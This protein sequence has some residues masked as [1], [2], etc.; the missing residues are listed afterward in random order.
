MRELPEFTM[1]PCMKHFF[2]GHKWW[3]KK[4]DEETE[5]QFR[6]V[7][8]A[9]WSRPLL[10]DRE[11]QPTVRHVDGY[12]MDALSP[13]PPYPLIRRWTEPEQLPVR[14]AWNGYVWYTLPHLEGE[15]EDHD[16]NVPQV[17]FGSFQS[18]AE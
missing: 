2:K 5:R 9:W 11:Q 7:C 16:P 18:P 17:S 4:C 15:C 10:D 6:D 1:P 14:V 13:G 8:L 3:C 12:R